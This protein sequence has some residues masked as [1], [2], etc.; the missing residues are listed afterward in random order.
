[1]VLLEAA[2]RLGP[3]RLHFGQRLT[4]FESCPASGVRARFGDAR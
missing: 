1:M 4:S 2:A 3:E